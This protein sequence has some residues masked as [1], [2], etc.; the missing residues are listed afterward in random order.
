LEDIERAR[1]EVG[2][3][4]PPIDKLRAG[5]NHPD[6]ISAMANR[7]QD[8]LEQVPAEFR[9]RTH[10][11]YTAHSIPRAMAQGCPY[12]MQLDEAC[13]LVSDFAGCPEWSLAF[14]SRS[15]PPTQPW[16]EPDLADRLRQIQTSGAFR[17]VVV[18]PIGFI[19]DHMEVL[20]DLD[21]EA[22]DLCE[23]LG[24]SMVRAGTVGTHPQFVQMIIQLIQERRNENLP[25]CALG[26]FGPSPDVCPME[27][28][29]SGR[30]R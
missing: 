8:A 22:K 21:V 9:P 30:P 24:L 27:C 4:A 16:L 12:E 17:A 15:G 11:V 6:F 14:Q 2:E 3:G 25:R 1:T 10:V 23:S 28:C 13:R 26:N 19:S 5:F 20:Y 29:P 7:V 18:A